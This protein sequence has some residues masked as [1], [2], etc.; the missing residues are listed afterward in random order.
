MSS[1]TDPAV[2]PALVDRGGVDD[3]LPRRS[4]LAIA[5]AGHVVLG[6]E[7]ADPLL[8]AVVVVGA[9]HVREDVAS[10]VVEGHERRVVEPRPR[11]RLIQDQSAAEGLV[12]F[13][14]LR[15]AVPPLRRNGRVAPIVTDL[16]AS[17]CALKS[18]VVMTL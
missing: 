10:P 8:V 3:G 4:G 2:R 1:S 11:N 16:S 6:I 18:S 13:T 9:A 7:P 17:R 5:D 14:A 15:Y 12:T